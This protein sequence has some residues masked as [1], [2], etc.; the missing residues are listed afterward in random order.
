MS[1]VRI[2]LRNTLPLKAY[3]AQYEF[4][5]RMANMYELTKPQRLYKHYFQITHTAYHNRLR[6][7]MEER[8]PNRT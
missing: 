2:K 8:E 4:P 3:P 7:T 1:P 6:Q 5:L